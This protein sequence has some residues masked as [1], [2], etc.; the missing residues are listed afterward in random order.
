MTLKEIRQNIGKEAF[1]IN[2]EKV[3]IIKPV[4]IGS[5]MVMAGPELDKYTYVQLENLISAKERELRRCM[6]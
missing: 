6:K 5:C 2:D 1:L 3:I 4:G